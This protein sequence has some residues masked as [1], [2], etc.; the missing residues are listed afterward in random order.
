[1]DETPS[2][3]RVQNHEPENHLST[4]PAPAMLNFSVGLCLSDGR[5]NLVVES[6]GSSAG[7]GGGK[8]YPPFELR[9]TDPAIVRRR[10]GGGIVG[11]GILMGV[12]RRGGCL[13]NGIPLDNVHLFSD[14]TQFADLPL[15]NDQGVILGT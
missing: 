10:R 6:L 15:Q 4:R 5:E 11:V 1:M 2:T 3:P 14:G 8:S 9:P 13:A 12:R 7:T